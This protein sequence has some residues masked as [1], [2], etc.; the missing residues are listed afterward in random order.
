MRNTNGSNV[1]RAWRQR[2]TAISAKYT[3]YARYRWPPKDASSAQIFV[4][5]GAEDASTYS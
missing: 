4:A 5:A 2:T 1:A 3:K